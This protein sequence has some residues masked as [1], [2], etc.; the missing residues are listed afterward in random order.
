MLYL[1]RL[2]CITMALYPPTAVAAVD[3]KVSQ[4]LGCFD[5]HQRQLPE[6]YS[7]MND[8][9]SREVCMSYCFGVGQPLAGVEGQYG[10][11]CRCG[12][13]IAF[14]Q[15]AATGCDVPCA[16]NKNE[17]CGGNW[18]VKIFNFT[19]E[20][21]PTPPPTNPPP[22]PAPVP[23]WPSV[24]DPRRKNQP[25]VPYALQPLQWGSVTPQGWIREWAQAARNGAVSPTKAAFATLQDGHGHFLG[26]GWRNGRP[27]EGGFWD[28]DSAYWIDGMTRLGLVLH[29]EE[30]LARVKEDYEYVM[31]HPFNFHNTWKLDAVEGWVRSIYSRGMLAYYDGTGDEAIIAFLQRAYSNYTAED[32]RYSTAYTVHAIY[33]AHLLGVV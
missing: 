14:P 5:D 20:T 19:C 9:M 8:D 24:H 2:V 10:N 3:C 32:S 15:K 18:V 29:D 33:W 25:K 23:V 31:S 28:E 17:T 30:L 6:K 26:D 22:T 13:T 1:A 11:Q 4:E 21:S 16:A 7:L 27:Q 12:K